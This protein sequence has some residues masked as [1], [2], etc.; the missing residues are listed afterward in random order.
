MK[1][2]KGHG[3][4]ARNGGNGQFQSRIV[5]VGAQARKINATKERLALRALADQRKYMPDRTSIRNIPPPAMFAD[6][7]LAGRNTRMERTDLPVV[8]PHGRGVEN[9]TAGKKLA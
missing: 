5:G 6:A 2:A 1:D 4:D 3:S 7:S 9:A 8:S